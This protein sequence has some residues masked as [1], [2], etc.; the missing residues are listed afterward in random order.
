MPSRPPAPTS[1]RARRSSSSGDRRSPRPAPTVTA[2]A[3][4]LR[5]C[6]APSPCPASMTCAS[7]GREHGIEHLGVAPAGVLERAR[8]ALHDRRRAGLD[9]GMGFTYRNPDRSTDPG[10][11]VPGA[12]SISSPPARTSP[13]TSH[14]GP[15]GRQARVARYA[16]V[17]HYAPAARRPAGDGP[18]A[19]RPRS[20][21]RRLRRRQLDRRP[22]GRPPGRARLV[23]QE[24]QRPAA[25]RRELVRPR[26]RRHHGRPAGRRNRSPTAAAPA[27][28]ASTPA[29]PAPSSP[30][31]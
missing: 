25:R 20:P 4:R 28:A 3:V 12:R 24:R 30:P 5:P 13:T 23:R 22:R 17:D 19:A 8:Q 27:G 14:R 15:P 10:R 18:P 26:L 2:A 16:W 9:A 21:G 6:A 31:V 11:A 29:R 1:S 7:I